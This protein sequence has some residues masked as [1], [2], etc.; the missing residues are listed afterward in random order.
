MGCLVSQR[1]AVMG[2]SAVAM[3]C[4]Q[5]E[6]PRGEVSRGRAHD[7]LQAAVDQASAALAGLGVVGVAAGGAVQPG[8]GAVPV[9]AERTARVPAAIAYGR[10]QA[11]QVAERRWQAGHHGWP[12]AREMP[13]PVVV[14]ADR[15]GQHGEC[16]AS[17]AERPVEV[18]RLT[19]RRRP[20]SGR[21]PDSPGR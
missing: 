11:E 7:L 10:P 4:A 18:R 6:Q 3:S 21:S 16:G 14:A 1:W 8:W 19:G 12:V 9:G 13:H 5:C 2:C 15:A 20:Q 17:R